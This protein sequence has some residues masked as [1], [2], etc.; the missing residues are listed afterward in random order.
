MA[1]RTEDRRLEC[2]RSRTMAQSLVIAELVLAR[3]PSPYVAQR[4]TL[5]GRQPLRSVQELFLPLQFGLDV[6]AGRLGTLVTQP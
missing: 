3:I 4:L 1:G 5:T 2:A 6:Q